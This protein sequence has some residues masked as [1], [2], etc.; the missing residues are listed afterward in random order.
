[1]SEINYDGRQFVGV[2]NTENGEVSGQT[3]FHYRQRG[4]VVW[5]TYEG[6]GVRLGTLV[7]AVDGLGRLDMRYAHVNSSGELMTGECRSTP[8]LL[9][10][11]RLRIHERWRWTS[12][13][14][15]EGESVV[16]E[17]AS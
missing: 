7:A 17:V 6:G 13:D 16:E 9:A 1:M 14:E 12:G 10:D 15:S 3:V 11:G 5:A 2:A 8:E 4:D